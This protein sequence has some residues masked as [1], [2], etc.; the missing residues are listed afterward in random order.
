MFPGVVWCGMTW[1]DSLLPLTENLLRLA[2]TSGHPQ[3]NL[4]ASCTQLGVD[5]H[6]SGGAGCRDAVQLAAA[7]DFNDGEHLDALVCCCQGL[8][9]IDELSFVP[10]TE[11]NYCNQV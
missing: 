11:C 1:C 3:T 8:D 6:S 10:V 5:A 2:L 9:Y 7:G 4:G